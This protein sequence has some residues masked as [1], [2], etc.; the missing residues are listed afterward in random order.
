MRDVV[1]NQRQPVAGR[2]VLVLGAG[3]AA[4]GIL[5]PLLAAG[6]RELVIANRTQ[7][8]AERLLA[9][10]GAGAAHRGA[11]RC[12]TS[13]RAAPFDIVINATSAGLQ[14]EAPPFPKSII[15]PIS[16]CYDLVYSVHDTP[17]VAW[18]RQD[19][20]RQRGAGVGHAD[21]AGGRIVLHLARRSSGYGADSQ[22][23]DTLAAR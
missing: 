6:P 8:R 13:S 23:A 11:S 12:S 14:G 16:F 1:V 9:G 7:E 20:A 21:R 22:A 17:F 18:A 10:L 15:G 19:G 5:G 4:R 3:G 2:R